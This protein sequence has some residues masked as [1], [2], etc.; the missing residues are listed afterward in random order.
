MKKSIILFV[1]AVTFFAIALTA[2]TDKYIN[3]SGTLFGYGSPGD[4]Y[5]N[6]NMPGKQG[7][8]TFRLPEH[9]DNT[10]TYGMVIFIARVQA[11][12][13]VIGKVSLWS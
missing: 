4:C 3:E 7:T 13:P 12:H 9:A 10:Q 8:F 1:A 5:C 6:L 2:Q 11:Y